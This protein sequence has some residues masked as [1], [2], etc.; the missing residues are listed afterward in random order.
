MTRKSQVVLC[1][2]VM[3]AV[4]AIAVST[5]AAGPSYGRCVPLKGGNYQDAGC[6]KEAAPGKRKFEWHY[7]GSETPTPE[8][9]GVTS[10][11]KPGSTAVLEAVKG[12][13]IVCTSEAGSGQLQYYN[14]QALTSMKFEGC[15]SAGMACTTA[16]QTA[17]TILGG[18]AYNYFGWINSASKKGGVLLYGSSYWLEFECAAGP[19][20]GMHV[21]IY[22]GAIA[23]AKFG[24]MVT[25]ETLK[26]TQ[27]KGKQKPEY[28]E[29]FGA[30]TLR[31]YV[32]NAAEEY[33][34]EKPFGLSMTLV[35]TYEEKWELNPVL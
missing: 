2:V 17:G 33:V 32:F 12:P 23:P 3:A 9:R 6:T 13:Q 14:Y 11:L 16:G 30:Y 8:N 19:L 35:Q 5:A 26:W 18:P 20:A 28:G 4:S 29:S 21:K 34:E 10:T 22:N 27:S 24:K 25:S 7:L 31:G 15:T 1:I